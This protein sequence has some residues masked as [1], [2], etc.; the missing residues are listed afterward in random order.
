M[1]ILLKNHVQI[2]QRDTRRKVM[3]RNMPRLRYV[4]S[5]YCLLFFTGE[6]ESTVFSIVYQELPKG[7]RRSEKQLLCASFLIGPVKSEEKPLQGEQG[8]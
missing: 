2:I 4:C 3:E 5:V 1:H 7:M 6:F 8:G